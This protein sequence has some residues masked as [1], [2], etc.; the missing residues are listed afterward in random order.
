MLP[1]VLFVAPPLIRAATSFPS[2]V[3]E[4]LLMHSPSRELPERGFTL[5]MVVPGLV[6]VLL[7]AVVTCTG[8]GTFLAA[9]FGQGTEILIEV[10][11]YISDWALSL[12]MSTILIKKI[13]VGFPHALL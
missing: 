6:M 8:L 10:M 5:S 13:R 4:N 2:F 12:I 7:G 3:P 9:S 1:F 11:P